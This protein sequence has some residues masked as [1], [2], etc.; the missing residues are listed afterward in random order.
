MEVKY[1]Y[2][3]EKK[4][5]KSA[6]LSNGFFKELQ[7]RRKIR[8]AT[9][10][11]ILALLASGK[12]FRTPLHVN[13]KNGGHFIID[14]NHRWEAIRRFLAMDPNNLVQVT[15]FVY[16]N[17]DEDEEKEV[18]TT[19]NKANKQNTNDVVKQYEDDI[20]VLKFF[21]NGWTNGV[22]GG[23]KFPITV[24]I[25]PQ[26]GSV[27]FYK[28]V[29]AYIS[30]KEPIFRGGYIGTPWEFVEEASKL[31]LQDVKEM[32]AF[33]TDYMMAFGVVPKNNPWLG[34]TPITAVMKIWF[35]N[36]STVPM[37]Q[38]VKLFKKKIYSDHKMLEYTKSG[39]AGATVA[40]HRAYLGA[41][42]TQRKH[43]FI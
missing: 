9:V 5:V 41:L 34:G 40:A 2:R 28:L 6:D 31:K 16:D 32:S 37:A 17:L 1:D 18:Y 14:G 39:G 3:V 29:G 4:I 7:N 43:V 12:H 33:I 15:L 35:D 38:M 30:C 10:R 21:K 23:H 24:S 19:V 26:P 36:K 8:T 42:N 22:P 11:Q 20:Q 27:T 25:Y 13:D